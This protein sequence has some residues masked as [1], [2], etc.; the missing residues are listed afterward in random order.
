LE[1]KI[2]VKFPTFPFFTSTLASDEAVE[3]DEADAVPFL[4]LVDADA[5]LDDDDDDVTLMEIPFPL[6]PP[7]LG[8]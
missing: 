1:A 8:V 4:P 3:F 7:L 6:P 2:L 5:E